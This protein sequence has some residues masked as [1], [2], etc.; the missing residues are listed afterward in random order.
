IQDTFGW[1]LEK[2]GLNGSIRGYV[3]AFRRPQALGEAFHALRHNGMLPNDSLIFDYS[4]VP[5]SGTL[6][7]LG[8][9]EK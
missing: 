7:V 9:F 5:V 8:T 4:I 3:V 1:Q 2:T 6:N